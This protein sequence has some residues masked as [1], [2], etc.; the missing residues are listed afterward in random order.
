MVRW[1]TEGREGLGGDE[2]EA[3]EGRRR[4]RREHSER[5]EVRACSEEDLEGPSRTYQP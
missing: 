2:S 3:E 1:D 4:P 5:D